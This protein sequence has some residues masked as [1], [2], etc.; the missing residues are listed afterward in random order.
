MCYRMS[1]I[2]VTCKRLADRLLAKNAA[3]LV[4]RSGGV[5]VECLGWDGHITSVQERAH[6]DVR[7]CYGIGGELYTACCH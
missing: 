4:R 3:T 2:G 5:R 7:G 6:L 1:L